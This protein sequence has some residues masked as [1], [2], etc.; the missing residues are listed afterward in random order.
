MPPLSVKELV[1]AELDKAY[2]AAAGPMLA[3]IG[4]I[5]R[6][7]N[8]PM[9]QSLKKLDEEA[10][11]LAGENEKMKADNAQLAQTMGVYEDNLK[12]TETLIRA[13]D[14]AIQSSGQVLALIGVTAQIFSG[15][16]QSLIAAK[17]NPISAAAIPA[18]TD[19]I[20]RS[21]A[22]WVFPSAADIAQDFVTSDAWIAKMEK[23]GKGYA[24]LTQKTLVNGIR[25]GWG[26][27]KIAREMRKHAA[28]I[29]VAASENLTRTLQLNSYREASL[30]METVNNENITGKIRVASLD[31]RT[32][33]T[34]IA[35]HGTP[36]ALG[37]SVDDHY[38][39]RCDVFYIVPGGLQRPE[40]MQSDSLPG[41]RKFVPFQDGPEWFDS[42]PSNR[43]ARQ[44]SFITS[45]AKLRAFQQGTPLSAFVGDHVDDV[46]GHQLIE[47]S[48]VGA[49]GDDA[50]QFYT[51]NQPVE[52]AR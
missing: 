32:C 46:F 8:S 48:L 19:L 28:N 18:Y 33:L 1:G 15:V 11:R 47:N 2:K 12:A 41:D 27:E 22:R 35:L 16:T 10:E 7:E 34:C 13:N 52:V 9:Q 30:A 24:N 17:K 3:Q 45:P 42:L 36:L 31:N 4:A 43:Q 6:A 20:A 5:S 29:P 50:A 21:G 39:G 49:L 25:L 38:R 26:P 23:W 14:D 44:A 51:I 40:F 37:E